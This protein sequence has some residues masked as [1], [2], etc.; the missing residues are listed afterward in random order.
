METSPKDLSDLSDNDLVDE[1]TA[2]RLIGGSSTPIHRSTLWRGINAGRYPKP[3]KISAST[4]RWRVSELAAV[5]EKAAAAR[6][7]A[8]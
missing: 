4:N 5:V 6:E 2:C 1:A 8:A 7:E 3:L